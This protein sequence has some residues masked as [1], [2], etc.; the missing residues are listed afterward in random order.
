MREGPKS[1]GLNITPNL[2]DRLAIA[3]K[4]LVF[5]MAFK[6]LARNLPKTGD[7]PGSFFSC[8][9]YAGALRP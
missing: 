2:E 1:I 4:Y 7:P 3:G 8:S 6:K 5:S 9:K